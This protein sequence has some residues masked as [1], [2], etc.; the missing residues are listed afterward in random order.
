MENYN[1]IPIRSDEIYRKI[2]EAS[3][4]KKDDNVVDAEYEEK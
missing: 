3:K 1:I 4:D 2:L